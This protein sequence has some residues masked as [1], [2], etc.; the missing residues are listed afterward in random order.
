MS[1][2]P[3]VL[4]PLGKFLLQV[5]LKMLLDRNLSDR[6]LLGEV[7]AAIRFAEKVGQEKGLKNQEKTQLALDRIKASSIQAA[8]AATESELRTLIEMKLDKLL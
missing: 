2:L 3:S 1:V 6:T 7:E 5:G 8:K 4:K